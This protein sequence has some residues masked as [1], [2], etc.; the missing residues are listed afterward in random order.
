MVLENYFFHYIRKYNKSF[1]YFNFLHE[2]NFKKIIQNNKKKLI[3]IGDD[4]NKKNKTKK[5]IFSFDDG[6]KDHVFASNVLEKNN[7]LGQFFINTLPII[8]KEIL[9][10]HKLHLM[11][12][13][14]KS[15]E[16]IKVVYKHE[17]LNL[18]NI[19]IPIYKK[20]QLK[21]SLDKDHIIKLKL[22]IFLSQKKNLLLVSKIFNFF[23]SK[24]EQKKILEGLYLNIDDIINIDKKGM[25]IGGHSH[26]HK[27][28]STLSVINQ[29]KEIKKN[30]FYL[31]K[32]LNKKVEY[33]ASPW[34]H[35]NSYSN[36][37]IKI[38][39]KTVKYHFTTETKNNKKNNYEIPR[40]NCN[41]LKGGNIY[42]YK[43]NNDK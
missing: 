18:K 33:F 40:I 35:K 6:L 16:L 26:S 2:K 39:K 31:S 15:N 7:I 27:K 5:Y 24:L 14:Y 1:P 22:K 21:N 37:T 13:K 23:F 4:I 11:F 43:K 17:N 9:S 42:N 29:T 10:V 32:I 28:L 3:K 38:L 36:N 25:I 20:Y 34:G 8:D 30:I 19:K 41:K 12:G